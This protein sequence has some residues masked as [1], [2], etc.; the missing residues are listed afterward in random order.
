[1][2]L[3]RA[4]CM[5][6]GALGTNRLTTIVAERTSPPMPARSNACAE[7]SY[8]PSPAGSSQAKFQDPFERSAVLFCEPSSDHT[9]AAACW[10]VV[11]ANDAVVTPGSVICD[12]AGLVI[13]TESTPGASIP[14]R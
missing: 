1:M 12:E 7:T 3:L 6:C 13:W 2:P 4:S 11:T 8:T 10:V 9:T 14:P 5:F